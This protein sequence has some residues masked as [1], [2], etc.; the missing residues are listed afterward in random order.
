MSFVFVIQRE[1]GGKEGMPKPENTIQHTQDNNEKDNTRILCSFIT[2][3]NDKSSSSK[4]RE[5]EPQLGFSCPL[6]GFH[7]NP[8]KILPFCLSNKI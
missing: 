7:R 5:V 8:I 1:Q 4:E 2:G 6:E 3:E